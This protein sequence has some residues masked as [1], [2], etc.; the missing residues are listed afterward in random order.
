MFSIAA[1]AVKQ[2]LHSYPYFRASPIRCEGWEP[3]SIPRTY[4]YSRTTRAFFQAP[5]GLSPARIIHRR[6]HIRINVVS[7]YGR[8]RWERAPCVPE[9]AY[10]QGCA[11]EECKGTVTP[12][13]LNIETVDSFPII[14]L[15][16]AV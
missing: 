10:A 1:S 6:N 8:T 15:T 14:I 9:M 11:F 3:L 12:V 7:G 2:N 4:L 5:K 16:E 13:A